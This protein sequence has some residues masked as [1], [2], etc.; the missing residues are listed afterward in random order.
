MSARVQELTS[1]Y[2]SVLG[3]IPAEKARRLS[4]LLFALL[5][6]YLLARLFW[7]LL[8]VGQA[9]KPAEIA[10]QPKTKDKE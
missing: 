3:K 9:E 5:G 1:H 10:E 6:C 2:L 8:P 4:M 7:L